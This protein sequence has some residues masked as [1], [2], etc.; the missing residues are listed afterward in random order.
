MG[1]KPWIA[2]LAAGLSLSLGGAALADRG[3]PDIDVGVRL[4][5]ANFSALIGT[6]GFRYWNDF[7]PRHHGYFG[8]GYRTDTFITRGGYIERVYYRRGR[9]VDSV[10]IGRVDRW[11]N[12]RYWNVRDRYGRYHDY[13][14]WNR[15][16]A[17]WDDRW[18]RRD[19]RYD[20]R[21]DRRDRRRDWRDHR[22]DDRRDRRDRRD[23][24]Y[25]DRR[26]RRD[27]RYDDRRDRRDD[28]RDNRRDRRDSRYDSPYRGDQGST[29]VRARTDV[30]KNP[31]K[32]LKDDD[33]LI[34]RSESGV[35]GRLVKEKKDD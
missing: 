17:R 1:T 24:R 33:G 23:D 5:G 30:L 11:G 12:H 26:D 4:D 34:I 35:V 18:D 9:I 28:R 19:R 10:I 2:A 29:G 22:Y 16:H 15:R 21:D 20:W 6:D 27:D 8:R 32:Y 13:R 3:G 14:G 7:Y 25:D 31:E